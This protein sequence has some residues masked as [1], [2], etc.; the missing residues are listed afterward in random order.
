MSSTCLLNW[1]C[2]ET[3]TQSTQTR[4]RYRWVVCAI[5]PAA[6][7]V[8]VACVEGLVADISALKDSIVDVRQFKRFLKEH[9]KKCCNWSANARRIV[10]VQNKSVLWRIDLLNRRGCLRVHLLCPN[11]N[12][13]SILLA[14]YMY[15]TLM[16]INVMSSNIA[17][18]S[19]C[20]SEY[21]YIFLL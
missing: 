16:R 2:S 5:F 10:T 1:P 6:N 4:T 21:T 19:L 3:P 9:A 12:T 14:V 11:H 15:V 18:S 7:V 8:F 13:N 17:S 20:T